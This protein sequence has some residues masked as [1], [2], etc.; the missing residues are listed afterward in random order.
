MLALDIIDKAFEHFTKKHYQKLLQKFNVS[1]EELKDAIEEI[2]RLNPKPGGSYSGNTR[3]IEH[4]VPDFTIRIV[5][6][7]LELTLNG[8]NAPELRVSSEYPQHA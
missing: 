7:E 2:E 6:G 1:E 3:I 8:R 5:E 4:I